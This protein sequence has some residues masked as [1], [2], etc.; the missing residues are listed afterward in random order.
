[1]ER[2]GHAHILKSFLREWHEFEILN[3][4]VMLTLL[5]KTTPLST[6][7]KFLAGFNK[8]CPL[9]KFYAKCIHV[10]D[11]LCLRNPATSQNNLTFHNN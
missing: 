4:Q 6:V 7:G 8:S 1:M 5:L 11:V 9:V 3:N 10:Q 2:M